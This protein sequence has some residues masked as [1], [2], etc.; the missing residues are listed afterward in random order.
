MT[1]SAELRPGA[2]RP[3]PSALWEQ[4]DRAV[5]HLGAAMEGRIMYVVSFRYRDLAAV[6][7]EIA[8]ALTGERGD[9]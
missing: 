3:G 6:M 9:A 7:H 8:D 5:N 1:I 2:D 4:F